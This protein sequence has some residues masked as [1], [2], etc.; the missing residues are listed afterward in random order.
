MTDEYRESIVG[1]SRVPG[2]SGA[3]VVDPDAGVTVVEELRPEVAGPAT[4]ALAA[5]L[6][7]RTA[8]AARAAGLQRLDS[9][10]LEAQGGQVLIMDAGGLIVVALIEDDGQMGRVRLEAHRAARA[11]RALAEREG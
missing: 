7:Q 4:A 6:F 9:L 5:A 10:Q 8:Q 1:L 2:V 11:L 3:L